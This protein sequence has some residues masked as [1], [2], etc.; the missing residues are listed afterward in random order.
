METQ[1]SCYAVEFDDP[2]TD[3]SDLESD[4]VIA[5]VRCKWTYFLDKAW[6]T[7]DEGMSRKL[8]SS[9]AK[10]PCEC[11]VQIDHET[12]VVYMPKLFARQR[13]HADTYIPINRMEDDNWPSPGMSWVYQDASTKQWVHFRAAISEVI[14]NS[15]LQ[16]QSTVNILVL[17]DE[18]FSVLFKYNLALNKRGQ[19]RHVCRC[20]IIVGWEIFVP[21]RPKWTKLEGLVVSD[22]AIYAQMKEVQFEDGVLYAEELQYHHSDG[23]M[24]GA[25][26]CCANVAVPEEEEW[27][28]KEKLPGK[29]QRQRER[30][31]STVFEEPRLPFFHEG[32]AVHRQRE[33]EGSTIF[34]EERMPVFHEARTVHRQREKEFSMIFEEERLPSFHDG[35]ESF[36]KELPGEPLEREDSLHIDSRR[37]PR[38]MRMIAPG[39]TPNSNSFLIPE[40]PGETISPFASIHEK[41]RGRTGSKGALLSPR[42]AKTQVEHQSSLQQHLSQEASS[43]SDDFN[44]HNGRKKRLPLVDPMRF[45]LLPEEPSFDDDMSPKRKPSMPKIKPPPLGEEGAMDGEPR[46]PTR[47]PRVHIKGLPSFATSQMSPVSDRNELRHIRRPKVDAGVCATPDGWFELPQTSLLA[48]PEEARV[49]LLEEVAWT[50]GSDGED[51]TTTDGSPAGSQNSSLFFSP[52]R[53]PA[54]QPQPPPAEPLED[55]ETPGHEDTIGEPEEEDGTEDHSLELVDYSCQTDATED[56]LAP[57]LSLQDNDNGPRGSRLQSGRDTEDGSP[58]CEVASA[59]GSYHLCGGARGL[60][61][62]RG[63]LL[64]DPGQ[65]APQ[66]QRRP[67]DRAGRA[68]DGEAVGGRQAAHRRQQPPPQARRRPRPHPAPEDRLVAGEAADRRR[69]PAAR[70]RR[71]LRGHR[72]QPHQVGCEGAGRS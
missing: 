60:H 24:Y 40:L 11:E 26:R 50:S 13:L 43:S 54:P 6:R 15:F 18:W 62:L 45:P 61:R 46:T 23:E 12:W 59:P 48:V 34:E 67:P 56:D 1:S 21:T 25:R 37:T 51:D 5:P 47:R 66:Q 42:G 44:R 35:R 41:S 53:Q 17:G 68:A 16:D 33:K 58:N 10:R 3:T 19:Y 63:V 55:E 36:H 69:Q 70:A 65:C 64:V 9:W 31:G 14:E 72:Q 29:K 49:H 71:R 7:F 52:K 39:D 4:F 2:Q 28:S 8:E 22:A 57:L 38:S 20:R 32:R 27:K 30:T